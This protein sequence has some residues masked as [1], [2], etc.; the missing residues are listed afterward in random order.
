MILLAFCSFF[1]FSSYS[2][3]HFTRNDSFIVLNTNG[4]TLKNAWAGGFNSVQFSEIDLDLDGTMDLLAFDKADNRIIPF[5]NNGIAN[6][7]SYKHA[8]EYIPYFPKLHDWVLLR[9]YNCDG[10][11]DIFTYSSGGMAIYKNTSTTALTFV[12]MVDLLHSDFQPNLV[13]LYVSSQDIPAIDDIDGDGDLDILTFSVLGSIVEYHKN[14]SIETYGN[15]DSLKYQIRNKCWGFFHENLSSNSVTLDDTCQ[16][17]IPNPEKISGGNKHAGSTL[18]TLDVDAN[19]SKELV[20]GDVSFDNL[21]L[22]INGDASPNLDKSYI[23]AQDSEFPKNNNNTIA[24]EINIFPAGYYLDVTNDNIKDLIISP[25]CYIG[26]KNSNNTWLYKNNGADNNPDFEL[27][28]TSFLQDEMIETGEGAKPVFFDYNADGLLDIVI[29]N[30]GDFN[31]NYSTSY[32]SSLWLYEN[33][34]TATVPAYQLVDSDYVNISSMN[35]DLIGSQPTLRITPTFG[36][37]DGD[38]DLDMIIGD[39]QGFL[40]YFINNG[41]AGNTANFVLNEV[42]Y[43]GI[44]V[45]NF[46]SPQL[47]DLNKDNLLDLVIGKKSGYITYYQNVGTTTSPSFN[48]VTDSL[49][50]VKT[51]TYMETSVGNS[52]PFFFLNATGDYQLISGSKNGN[53]Y[54]YD[55]I[56]GNL[57]GTFNL[58]D[59]TYLNIWEGKSSFVNFADL[60]NDGKIDMVIGNTSGGVAFYKGDI[61]TSVGNIQNQLKSIRIFPNPT[62]NTI[63]IN[64]GDNNINNAT[65][66]VVNILGETIISKKIT[67]QQFIIDLNLQSDGIYFVRFINSKGTKTI[68]VIKN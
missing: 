14:L 61:Y 52:T 37:I 3:L 49:G 42:Q 65:I 54:A 33:I 5:I 7:S 30:Y 35:L 66:S 57:N 34:G 22:L 2:Q 48:F 17:N 28:N 62:Q 36:D 40:H 6:Q 9:D 16:W 32:K 60:T 24:A 58:I 18:F 51:R 8:P 21:T 63:T 15:C 10:K 20:L 43:R 31:S 64:V 56:D 47:V 25:N 46:A 45:G 38:N 11:M 41:G 44:D 50:Y 55:N 19:N 4:D 27:S 39:Y 13:N 59:S 26:C 53:L 67:S 23:T 12:K 1:Y 68:K 29:G